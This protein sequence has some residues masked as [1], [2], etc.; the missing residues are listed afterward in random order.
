[1]DQ[2]ALRAALALIVMFALALGLIVFARAY[3]AV[4]EEGL[5]SL[6]FAVKA[7][8]FSLPII[9][10]IFT[11]AAFLGIPQWVLIAAT[12]IAFGPV[13]GGLYAWL[14]TMVSA[15]TNFW[16]A[17]RLGAQK[18]EAV[19]GEF[20]ERMVRMV[21]QNGLLASFAVR[22]VPTGPFV[23]VN[24]A[25]GVSGL[26][27]GAFIL[28]TGAGII[29]KILVVALLAQGVLTQ[30]QGKAVM[31]FSIL[32]LVLVLGAMFLARRLLRPVVKDPDSDP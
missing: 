21:R 22:L 1:M 10:L 32:G 6:L 15:S 20:L 23:L 16:I 28:G 14:S 17:R 4:N 5:S 8:P 11:A 12:V 31:A 19:P 25:A 7:S 24:M 29:P 26:G 18:L 3:L 27:F 13:Q 30:Q 9:A 2:K